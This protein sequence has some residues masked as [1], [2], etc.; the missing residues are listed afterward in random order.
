MIWVQGAEFVSYVEG[1]AKVEGYC[2]WDACGQVAASMA[3][4]GKHYV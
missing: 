3:A 2:P 4:G 1:D